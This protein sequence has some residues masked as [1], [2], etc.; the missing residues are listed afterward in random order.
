LAA[1]NKKNE[2]Y[3]SDDEI[4][5]DMMALDQKLGLINDADYDVYKHLAP[6]KVEPVVHEGATEPKP[7]E[8]EVKEVQA[9]PI[10]MHERELMENI[11]NF[12]VTLVCGET[13]SGKSTQL[14]QFINSVAKTQPW[15]FRIGKQVD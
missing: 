11:F 15:K 8:E 7:D 10:L 14:P 2:E 5:A 3:D 1:L 12:V 9:L 6:V 13:G 4:K